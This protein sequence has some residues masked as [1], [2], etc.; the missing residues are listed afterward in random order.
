MLMRHSIRNNITVCIW[1]HAGAL[2][3][4]IIVTESQG[5]EFK[6]KSQK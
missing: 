5:E 1:K 2:V 4:R 6:R 3:I